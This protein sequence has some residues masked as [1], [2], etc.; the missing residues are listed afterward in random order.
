MSD[1]TSQPTQKGRN[2]TNK[3]PEG[4]RFT[5]FAAK[6]LSL[7]KGGLNELDLRKPISVEKKHPATT[8]NESSESSIDVIQHQKST[9]VDE[10]PELLRDKT[11]KIIKQTKNEVLEKLTSGTVPPKDEDDIDEDSDF[12]R[13]S[14]EDLN[15][16]DPTTVKKT[17]PNN[18]VSVDKEGVK[19]TNIYA[20]DESSW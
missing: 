7:M 5:S 13:M 6:N 9:E 11:V 18:Y 17:M 14:N 8:T 2:S 12:E 20:N 19:W 1:L 4:D 3:A 15:I 16:D 10:E